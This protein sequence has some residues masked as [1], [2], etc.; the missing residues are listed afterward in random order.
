M[1]TSSDAQTEGPKSIRR[2]LQRD[3][4]LEQSLDLLKLSNEDYQPNLKKENA[5]AD[6]RMRNR[7]SRNDKLKTPMENDPAS[8]K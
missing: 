2:E 8:S 6:V 3:S 7:C 4:D 5:S 1:G